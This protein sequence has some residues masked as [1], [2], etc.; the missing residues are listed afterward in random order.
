MFIATRKN[1]KAVNWNVV[2]EEAQ[3]LK[4]AKYI[5]DAQGYKISCKTIQ[6]AN[7]FLNIYKNSILIIK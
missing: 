7:K 4:I 1:K 3:Q 5:V 2:K 6:E